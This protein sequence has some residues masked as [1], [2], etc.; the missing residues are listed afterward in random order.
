MGPL[1]GPFCQ[2]ARDTGKIFGRNSYFM[3]NTATALAPAYTAAFAPVGGT[4]RPLDQRLG[5][6]RPADLLHRPSEEALGKI[7]GCAAFRAGLVLQF[8]F[9]LGGSHDADINPV[10]THKGPPKLYRKWPG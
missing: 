5:I 10:F 9:Q 1:V 4:R 6:S 2:L 3:I 7:A 8:P